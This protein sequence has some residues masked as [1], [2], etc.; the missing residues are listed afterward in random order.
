[1]ASQK[2]LTP[3]YNLRPA[4]VTPRAILPAFYQIERFSSLVYQSLHSTIRS[5][6]GIEM[7]GRAMPSD[8]TNLHLDHTHCRAICDEVGYRLREI[9]GRELADMSPYLRGLVD[10]L[11]KLDHVPSPSN[12][13]SEAF[14]PA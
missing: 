11:G 1:M 8:Q 6:S 3:D 12:V 9:M 10:Q 5:F 13:T 2:W 14:E 7:I 4:A